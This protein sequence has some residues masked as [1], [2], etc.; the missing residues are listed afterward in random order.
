MASFA[1]IGLGIAFELL[2]LATDVGGSSL[3]SIAGNW[4]YMA[5]EFIAIGVCAGRVAGR[6]EHRL[7]WTLLTV[8][9]A[10]WSIGDLLWAV[11][12]DDLAAPPFPSAADAL[13][14]FMYPCMYVALM[15]LM[16]SRLR[17]AAVAQWLDGAV[18][19]LA[20]GAIAA[21]LVT[22]TSVATG[23][24]FIAQSV[25]VAYPVLDCILLMLVIVTF[26]L[27]GWKPR[28][29][30]LVLG[31]GIALMAG[32]DII[33]VEQLAGGMY[34]DGTL[35]NVLYLASF[36][37][38]AV[39]AWVRADT[40]TKSVHE[41]PHTIMLTL[42]AAAASLA[43]LVVAAFVHIAP[44]AVALA[45]G[46]LVL[47][48][49]RSMLTYLENVRLLRTRAREAVTDVLT[50]LANRRQLIVDLEQLR[51]GWSRRRVRTLVFFDLDGFK[52]YNDTFG[53]PAG[54]AMLSRL[55]ARLREL[56]VE[57]G[58]AY[59]VGGDEFCILLDGRH[60]RDSRLVAQAATA[61]SERGRG[62]AVTTSVG[63]AILPEEAVDPDA[64][65]R[66]ADE[67]MYADKGRAHRSQTRDVL[68]Q[69][70]TERAPGL[71][72][73]V[74]GVTD[75]AA[76]VATDLGL[77]SEQIDE[78]I[79]AAELHDVG[80]LAIPDAILNKPGPLNPDEWEFMRQHSVIGER[81][82]SVAPALAPVATLVRASH[83]RWDG[84][85]YPDG[86]AGEEIPIGARIVAGCD[87]Y[88]AITADR[89]YQET[90]TPEEALAELR[91]N[92]GTQFDPAVVDAIERYIRSTVAPSELIWSDKSSR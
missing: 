73:H 46:A 72:H 34:L 21:T 83:E 40:D 13:Y 57:R 76:A 58:A 32:A 12:L 71:L 53:H 69:L 87:A 4:V 10:A 45:A 49:T 48:T 92:A 16:R 44:T 33:Y 75:L 68:M 82:L 19:T 23:H 56:I 54:D 88:E 39:A 30:L 41:A 26:A 43:L 90:R 61:L 79:R 24:R 38:F 20:V 22:A 14:L 65:L 25:Y 51:D 77:D 36:S 8:A 11:W 91:R 18:L 3:D 9:L 60:S 86:L 15:V 35:L 52:H 28:A 7:T 74:S 84:G 31:A 5:V 80:K 67:R 47:A 27:V 55:G 17:G 63:V 50:G 66:L 62:F 59:R 2:R 85:G 70:L 1:A 78:T 64:A 29:D 6:R 81:I 42:A 89:L 37:S